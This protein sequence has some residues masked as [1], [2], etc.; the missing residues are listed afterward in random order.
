MKA[1]PPA[2][3]RVPLVLTELD[4]L[5][6]DAECELDYRSPLELL[7]AV[8]D[9]CPRQRWGRLHCT[10]KAHGIYFEIEHDAD[11]RIGGVVADEPPF[12]SGLIGGALDG[13]NGTGRRQRHWDERTSKRLAQHQQIS[14]SFG[15][16]R[17]LHGRTP[18]SCPS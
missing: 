4:R 14:G 15:V 18:S 1:P 13:N 7:V 3:S 8:H 2:K 17:L 16:R 11:G 5:Y 9:S 6:P 10:G 12:E